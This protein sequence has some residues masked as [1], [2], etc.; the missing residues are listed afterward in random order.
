[1]SERVNIGSRYRDL[2]DS[3]LQGRS[4]VSAF[5]QTLAAQ[6]L[7]LAL[8]VATGVFTARILGPEGRGVFTA[9]TF[10]PQFMATLALFGVQNAII[11]HVRQSPVHTDSLVTAGLALGVLFAVIGGLVGCAVIPPAMADRYPPDVITFAMTATAIVT[12]ISLFTM[13]LRC[14][15]FALGRVGTANNSSWAH[16]MLYFA[17]LLVAWRTIPVTA[18]LAAS[19]QFLAGGLVLAWMLVRLANSCRL[20]FFQFRART[21]ALVSYSLRAAPGEC[22]GILAANLDRL[23]LVPLISAADLGLY[24]VAFSLSRLISVIPAALTPVALPAM[25]GRGPEQAKA[26][27][28]RLFRFTLYGLTLITVAGFL[29]GDWALRCFYGAAFVP[30]AILFKILLLEAALSTLS[31]LPAQLYMALARP[32]FLSWLQGISCVVT[33]VGLLLMVPLFGASGA[34][35]AMLFTAVFRLVGLLAGLRPVF[36]FGLPRL[37]PEQGDLVRVLNGFQQR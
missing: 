10:W 7:V 27:H 34:A 6:I 29:I 30:A 13:L 24:A 21:G 3:V 35:L 4:V 23:A 31:F 17:L 1:V 11:Y 18:E 14:V 26:L 28:D 8:N 16:P 25:A 5:S 12:A 20:D 37:M 15:F 32:G 22:L 33:L 19:C 2:V 9:V 36:G